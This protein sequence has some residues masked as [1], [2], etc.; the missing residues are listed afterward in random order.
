MCSRES[1][2]VWSD[3]PASSGRGAYKLHV[4]TGELHR[5]YRVHMLEGM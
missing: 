5:E 2:E 3:S 4:I 1:F